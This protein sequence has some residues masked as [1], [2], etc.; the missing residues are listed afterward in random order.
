MKEK[1][2]KKETRA[3]FPTRKLARL[4][5]A[6]LSC[7]MFYA[8]WVVRVEKKWLYRQEVQSINPEP[9]FRFSLGPEL[10]A[11]GNKKVFFPSKLVC[12][13]FL[14]SIFFRMAQLHSK[15]QAAA[16]VAATCYLRERHCL[17]SIKRNSRRRRRKSATRDWV[18]SYER[19]EG[20]YFFFFFFFFVCCSLPC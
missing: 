4:A 7:P 20:L 3:V 5:W 14:P 10:S 6:R 12:S 15:Q 2:K 16:R 13:A 17:F 11:P 19:G 8:N 9:Y 1:E 18:A